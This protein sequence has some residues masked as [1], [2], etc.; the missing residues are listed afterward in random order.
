MHILCHIKNSRVSSEIILQ[1]FVRLSGSETTSVQI[2][3]QNPALED[4]D[5]DFYKTTAPMIKDLSISQIGARL[6]NKF[7]LK[8]VMPG[9]ISKT[10]I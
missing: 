4:S 9:S 1:R 2:W 3:T 8:I 7:C 5:A 10:V 6:P